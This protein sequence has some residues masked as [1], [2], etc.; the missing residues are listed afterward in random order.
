MADP[1]D[2]AAGTDG[3]SDTSADLLKELVAH[4]IRRAAARSP[5]LS[6]VA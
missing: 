5:R 3:K 4:L 2:A 6:R 1:T